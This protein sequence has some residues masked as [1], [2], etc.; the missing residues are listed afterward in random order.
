MQ[1]A[2]LFVSG[3]VQGVGFRSAVRKQAALH[4]IRGYVRNLSDGRVEICAQGKEEQIDA[5]IRGIETK[6]GL[7]SISNIEK[8]IRPAGQPFSSFEII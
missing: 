6:P 8:I 5:F 2:H 4:Q 3:E 7:G 1:E